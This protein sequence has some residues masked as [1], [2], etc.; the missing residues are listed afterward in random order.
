M[1]ETLVDTERTGAEG[2][3][4]KQ[5]AG[6]REILQEV[7]H[8]IRVGEVVVETEC[9]GDGEDRHDDCCG[10]GLKADNKKHAAAKL[11]GDRNQ[12]AQSR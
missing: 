10:P 5:P 7:S 2:N 9:R 11:D 6:H 3:D 8:L 4:L 1:P 12:V